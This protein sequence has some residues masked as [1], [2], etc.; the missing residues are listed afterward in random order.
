MSSNLTFGNI[1]A[2]IATDQNIIDKTAGA[3]ID[4]SRVA[5]DNITNVNSDVTLT[6]VNAVNNA[7]LNALSTSIKNKGT[8]NASLNLF[9]ANTK[10]N[11]VYY[12]SVAGTVDGVDFVVNDRLISIVDNASE[13]VYAGNWAKLDN[14]D[15]VTS[16]FG[17]LG[18]ITAQNN[19]YTAAQVA[20]LITGNL[21]TTDLQSTINK[22]VERTT[23]SLLSVTK[24]RATVL[25][26]NDYIIWGDTQPTF[27]ESILAN[28]GFSVSNLQAGYFKCK[29][30]VYH[31]I[32]VSLRFQDPVTTSFAVF[33]FTDFDNGNVI[34]YTPEVILES[35]NGNTA[36]GAMPTAQFISNFNGF[37]KPDGYVKVGVRYTGGSS[38]A[39][40]WSSHLCVETIS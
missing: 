31:K 15:E 3:L 34:A 10:Q 30:G 26:I 16:V 35:T 7:I 23:P 25:N 17:R 18:A 27:G 24:G 28:R 21:D 1:N 8:W 20:N 36:N 39:L 13:T 5:P 32:L 37:S 12:V 29:I 6:T 38:G 9:P 2:K 33:Q 19:D 11:D 22:L 14:N 40:M 4:A